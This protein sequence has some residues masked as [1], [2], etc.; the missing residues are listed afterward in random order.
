MLLQKRD[1]FSAF[2]PSLRGSLEGRQICVLNY[3][4]MR[5]EMRFEIILSLELCRPICK[6]FCVLKLRFGVLG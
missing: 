4:E 6:P 2:A 3:L 5:F 1:V